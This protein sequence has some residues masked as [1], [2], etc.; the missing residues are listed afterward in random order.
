MKGIHSKNVQHLKFAKEG[1]VKKG[2]GGGGGDLDPD[3]LPTPLHQPLQ[4]A[5]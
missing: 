3:P 4:S 1:L 5:Q 2:R